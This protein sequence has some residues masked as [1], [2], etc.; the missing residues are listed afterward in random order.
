MSHC[1]ECPG[2]K[3]VIDF[4]KA[5]IEECPD[6]CHEEEIADLQRQLDEAK[7]KIGYYEQQVAYKPPQLLLLPGDTS[8]KDVDPEKVGDIVQER[9]TL[10]TSLQAM[11]GALTSIAKNT[12]CDRCQEAAL[13]AKKA[14]AEQP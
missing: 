5:M 3:L 8:V 9:D 13:V 2:G 10:R 4:P 1:P 6:C 7:R 14:L 12:C 11:R